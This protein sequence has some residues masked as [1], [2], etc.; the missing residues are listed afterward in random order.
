M[1]DTSNRPILASLTAPSAPI[2]K[3]E[4]LQ[5]ELAS[6]IDALP[7]LMSTGAVMRTSADSITVSFR[8]SAEAY[9]E[10]DAQGL[11]LHTLQSFLFYQHRIRGRGKSYDARVSMAYDVD[12]DA[13]FGPDDIRGYPLKFSW[14]ISIHADPQ[15][16]ESAVTRTR[17]LLYK[18]AVDVLE[19]HRFAVP[20]EI[21]AKGTL[22]EVAVKPAA[23]PRRAKGTVYPH[24]R[25]KTDVGGNQHWSMSPAISPEMSAEQ[26]SRLGLTPSHAE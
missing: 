4:K 23:A 13:Q 17:E 11:W 3:M 12:R 19:R 7:F 22:P 8:I 2:V 18:A 26:A 1:S 16:M 9:S 20:R 25:V 6:I 5:I 21:G 15:S 24:S 10:H 14:V